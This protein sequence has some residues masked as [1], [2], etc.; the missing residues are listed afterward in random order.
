MERRKFD[1][2]RFSAP[3]AIASMILAVLSVVLYF[4]IRDYLTARDEANLPRVTVDLGYARYSGNVLPSGV[5]QFLG[6]RYAAPPIGNLRWRAPQDPE[7]KEG[8]TDAIDV[9]R[10]A[11]SPFECC[12]R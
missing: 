8:T 12:P 1:W 5:N 7:P 6:M 3:V 11:V 2:R 9:R 10:L 4:N